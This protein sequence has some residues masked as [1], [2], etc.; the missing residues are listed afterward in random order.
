MDETTATTALMEALE[1]VESATS[2]LII[3]RHRDE[4][5]DHVSWHQFPESHIETLGMLEFAKNAILRRM[6]ES[7]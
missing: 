4:G 7:R 1:E 3:I 6:E 5:R 2:V